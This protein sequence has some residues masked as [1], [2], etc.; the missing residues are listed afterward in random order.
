FSEVPPEELQQ[1]SGS[2]QHLEG[3]IEA[4]NGKVHPARLCQALA[5]AAVRRGVMIFED[6]PAILDKVGPRAR[7]KAGNTVVD[8][9]RVVIASNIAAEA[10]PELAR[11]MVLVTS[12]VVATRPIADRLAE[13]GWT[14]GETI[15]DSQARLNY[16]RTTRAGRIVYG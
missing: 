1:R 9:E 6:A 7:I 8:A 16:Y 3:V 12:A 2:S 4:I 15:T 13:I 11:S 14:G 5:L 10:M